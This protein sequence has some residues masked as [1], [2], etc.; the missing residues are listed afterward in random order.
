MQEAL[1]CFALGCVSVAMQNTEWVNH[2]MTTPFVPFLTCA[3]SCQARAYEVTTTTAASPKSPKPVNSGSAGCEQHSAK[4]ATIT[5]AAPQDHSGGPMSQ[6]LAKGHHPGTSVPA[7]ITAPSN[8]NT[9]A[10]C[11]GTSSAQAVGKTVRFMIS[12][13]QTNHP[14]EILD[15]SMA[16]RAAIVRYVLVLFFAGFIGVIFTEH[17]SAWVE[18]VGKLTSKKT[19]ICNLAS[20]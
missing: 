5:G 6:G 1:A 18:S 8:S 10:S 12:E 11:S 15:G 17:K 19:M 9:G 2:V 20:G 14:D 13:A 4:K 7:S 16:S 3:L